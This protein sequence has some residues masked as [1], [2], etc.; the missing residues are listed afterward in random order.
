[1][2]RLVSLLGGAVEARQF[3]GGECRQ[4]QPHA[5][6]HINA[7]WLNNDQKDKAVILTL[8]RRLAEPH[9]PQEMHGAVNPVAD[10]LLRL[11]QDHRLSDGILIQPVENHV[12]LGHSP[13]RGIVLPVHRPV[14]LLQIVGEAVI[15]SRTV[16]A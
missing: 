10:L 3:G 1:M 11:D 15:W 7:A 13:L 16:A 9:V 5:V 2:G 4:T 12:H 8:A 14:R 6:V